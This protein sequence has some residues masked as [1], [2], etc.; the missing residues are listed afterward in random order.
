MAAYAEFY[1][2]QGA[3][4]STTI[5]LD[6][7]TTNSV[8]NVAGY[9]AVSSMRR[10]YYSANVTANLTCTFTDPSNGVLVLS[11]T[12]ANTA[13]ITPNRYLFDVKTT[14][15]SSE[16]TRILEGIITVLP[17]ITKV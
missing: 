15:P 7:D 10:S 5:T 13:N 12:A 14:S 4:F 3:T 17:Q 6:D 9:T 11:M 2:D 1:M 8:I 16:V